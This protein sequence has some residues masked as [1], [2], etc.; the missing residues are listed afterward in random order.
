MCIRDRST[1]R[2]GIGRGIERLLL[3]RRSRPMRTPRPWCRPFQLRGEPFVPHL[4]DP[5]VTVPWVA[6]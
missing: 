3:P 2:P 5:V 4:K 6:R 1:S